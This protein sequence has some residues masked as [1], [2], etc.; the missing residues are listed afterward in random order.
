VTIEPVLDFDLEIFVNWIN[1]L[2]TQ[3]S[4][5]YIWFGFDSK[6][7]YYG[8]AWDLLLAFRVDVG[9]VVVAFVA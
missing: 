5:E 2:K 4:L 3:G 1:K 8:G 6:N 9:R 7:E